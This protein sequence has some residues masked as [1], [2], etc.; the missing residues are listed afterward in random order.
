MKLQRQI[1]H[2]KL[3][4]AILKGKVILKNVFVGVLPRLD[5]AR[6]MLSSNPLSVAVTVITTNGVPK[7]ICASTTPGKVAARPIECKEKRK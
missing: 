6:V 1:K 3:Y 5:A 4:L 2:Q 7:I